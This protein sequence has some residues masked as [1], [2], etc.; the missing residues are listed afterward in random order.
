MCFNSWHEERFHLER[1]SHHKNHEEK[2]LN[3]DV[4][5]LGQ[6]MQYKMQGWRQNVVAFISQILSTIASSKV[7][8]C[9]SLQLRWKNGCFYAVRFHHLYPEILVSGSL[10]H[11]VCLWDA[12]TAELSYRF[13]C[14]PC[15][16]SFLL[17][18]LVTRS[19]TLTH[20]I[21]QRHLQLLQVTCIILH[22]LCTWLVLIPV[23]FLV[24]L[25][26]GAMQVW[27]VCNRE[28]ILLLQCG[29]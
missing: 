20:Q 12:N 8:Y 11:E 3:L 7:N 4:I 23:V 5:P 16:G 19:M 24:C 26:M 22:P 27:L 15:T 1:I 14:V 25:H 28:W 13:Y 17:W 29:L 10:D 21:S 18:L 9:S 6:G 2:L